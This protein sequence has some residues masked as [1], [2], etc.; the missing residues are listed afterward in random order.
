MIELAPDLIAHLGPRLSWALPSS[1]D[2][3][4]PPPMGIFTLLAIGQNG[5][6]PMGAALRKAEGLRGNAGRRTL[7]A[8]ERGTNLPGAVEP[9]Q[10]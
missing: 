4:E 2:S 10:P 9:V 7:F 6:K 5:M 3:F 1:P 8:D